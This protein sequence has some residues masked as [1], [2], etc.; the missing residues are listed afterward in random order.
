MNR[1]R[2]L[3]RNF[4]HLKAQHIFRSYNKEVDHLS[5]AALLLE[6][7]GI[8]C[9]RICEGETGNYERLIIN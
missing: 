2:K 3:N 6:K 9:A 4:T 5:K 8:H 1:I 7:D